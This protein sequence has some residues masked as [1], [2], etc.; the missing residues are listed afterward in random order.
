MS[1][2]QTWPIIQMEMNGNGA[3]NSILLKKTINDK[4]TKNLTYKKKKK[5]KKKEKK[6]K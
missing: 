3:E 1:I 5:E 4:V 6:K 2:Y